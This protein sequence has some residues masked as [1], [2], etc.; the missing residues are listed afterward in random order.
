MRAR[1]KYHVIY[2]HR[3]EYPVAVM[4]KFFSVSRSGC[5]TFAHRRGRPEKDAALAEIIAQ[6]Q[7]R[8][9]L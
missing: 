8:S 6:E 9:K 3:T 4:C 2:R 7:E 5:Y 1:V